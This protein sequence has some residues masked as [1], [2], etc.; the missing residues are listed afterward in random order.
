MWNFNLQHASLFCVNV[1]Q[2]KC[3]ARTAA[4]AGAAA[5]ASELPKPPRTASGSSSTWRQRSSSEGGCEEAVKGFGRGLEATLRKLRRSAK[6]GH[7]CCSESG[8]WRLPCTL[9]RTA[10]GVPAGRRRAD[11]CWRNLQTHA[12][13]AIGPFVELHGHL[14]LWHVPLAAAT[15]FPLPA[16]RSRQAAAKGCRC[17]LRRTGGIPAGKA[18]L[19]RHQASE[20]DVSRFMDCIV[21]RSGPWALTDMRCS[22]RSCGMARAGRQPLACCRSMA[23]PTQKDVCQDL[24]M[25][26]RAVECPAASAKR[27][28]RCRCRRRKPEGSPP[29]QLSPA[30][31]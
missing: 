23:L 17:L 1:R 29:H 12:G 8:G 31:G 27:C 16:A 7:Q 22:H 3:G 30:S 18:C 15:R 13:T 9:A 21:C 11:F 6:G 25:S 19:C 14:K 26:G 24:R 5:S 4:D 28:A 20:A 2:R 10:V